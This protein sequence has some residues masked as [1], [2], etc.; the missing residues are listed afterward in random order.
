MH[1]E[2]KLNSSPDPK[3]ASELEISKSTE[4]IVFKSPERFQVNS[5]NKKL[6]TVLSSKMS[7]FDDRANIKKIIDETLKEE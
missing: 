1:S 2:L 7:F 4:Y 5:E 3:G 6:P